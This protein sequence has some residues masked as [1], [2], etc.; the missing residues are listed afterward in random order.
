MKKNTKPP[1]I[2]E[3]KVKKKQDFQKKSGDYDGIFFGFFVFF[4]KK[5]PPVAEKTEKNFFSLPNS[6]PGRPL[7]KL[8][9]SK[10]SIKRGG[11]VGEKLSKKGS[12]RVWLSVTAS[13]IFLNSEHKV[14]RVGAKLFY[15]SR[16]FKK[17]QNH[18]KISISW[19]VMVN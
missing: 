15:E 10:R 2:F 19:K 18:A 4:A 8:G 12:N 13:Y 16:S 3:K 9:A 1:C 5:G 14:T 7:Q 11:G 17:T 6:P